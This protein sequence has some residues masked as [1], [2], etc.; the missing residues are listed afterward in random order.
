MVKPSLPCTHASTSA[1]RALDLRC[2]KRNHCRPGAAPG[3]RL[4][5][6]GGREANA[7]L[8]DATIPWPSKLNIQND[9]APDI[10]S[11]VAFAFSVFPARRREA[12]PRQL[13]RYCCAAPSRPH[14]EAGRLAAT[15]AKCWAVSIAALPSRLETVGGPDYGEG[16]N[17]SPERDWAGGENEALP[18]AAIHPVYAPASLRPVTPIRPRSTSERLSR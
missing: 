17:D 6:C 12:R 14:P 18:R 8:K 7:T 10:R 4:R 15:S 16:G 13:Q 3:H 11:G 2:V 1:I 9:V 5:V